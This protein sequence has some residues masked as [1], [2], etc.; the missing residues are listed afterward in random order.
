M[1]AIEG[2]TVSEAARY[3]RRITRRR[4]RNFYYGLKLA[5]EPQRSALF[6]IYA[7]MRRADDLVDGADDDTNGPLRNIEAF[8]CATDAALAGQIVD[9]DPLWVALADTA[10]GFNVDREALYAMLDGQI[11][12]LIGRRYQTFDQVREYCYRVASAV[13]LI[14]IEIWGYRDP[15]ARKLA[16]DR[17]IAFQL[18]NIL[19]DYKEDYDSGRVYLP[20]EDFARHDLT[21]SQVR[22]WSDPSRCRQFILEQ[23]ERTKSFYVRSASLEGLITPSCRPALW[24]MTS[25]YRS[26]LRK[27]QRAPQRI[28]IGRRLRLSPLRKG[29]IALRARCLAVHNNSPPP[30]SCV[31]KT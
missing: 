24:A 5:P 8:R 7:W 15:V 20:A 17:G 6:S 21:P 29:A 23:V 3:C 26:L 27:I 2:P 22:Q 11:D 25:I 4:A 18:T 28:I 19:R 30:E 12:D 13:G 14:C 16:V 31:T 10:T 1:S 9:G